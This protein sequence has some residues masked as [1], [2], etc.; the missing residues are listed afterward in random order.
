MNPN[1][2]PWLHYQDIQIDDVGL[3]NQF[4]LY[5][6]NGQYI[7]AVRL[8]RTSEEQL[9]GKA[10]IAKTITTIINGL[11][12]LQ[13]SFNTGVN[14]FLSDLASEYVDLINTLR[15]IGEWNSVL[16][17]VPY[18]FVSYQKDIYMAIKDVPINT[19]P[20]NTEYWLKLGL[21]GEDGADGV[22]VNLQYSWKIDTPYRDMDL[23]SYGTNLYLALQDN[24]GVQ[25]DTNPDIWLPFLVVAKGQINVGMNPPDNPE[26]DTIWFKTKSDP[27]VATEAVMGEFY[28]YSVTDT[29]QL[30]YPSVFFTWI[31]GIENYAPTAKFADVSIRKNRWRL[32]DGKYKYQIYNINVTENSY[33]EVS[34]STNMTE[35][36]EE[37][38]SQLSI[39]VSKYLIKLTADTKPNTS[40]DVR[41]KIQ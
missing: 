24:V 15:K 32:V 5:M 8:L 4:N 14:I 3:R 31:D 37:V 41:I 13:N 38:Y 39:E 20:T 10:Y 29:W 35:E 21:R 6:R 30:M 28:K 9:K 34:P 1:K 12:G 17:Y 19:L 25:P 11:L 27:L 7:D 40:F 33:V 23:V 16:T 22:D 18:N 2:I 26:I 36:Q